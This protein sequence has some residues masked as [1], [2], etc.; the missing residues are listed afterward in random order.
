MTIRTHS[1]NMQLIV[2]T[3]ECD[4]G[5][6]GAAKTIDWEVCQKHK[7]TLTADCTL[8]FSDPDG[9][10]NFVFRVIQDAVGGWNLTWP[11]NVKWPGGSAPNLGVAGQ[12]AANAESIVSV[13]FN[14]TD[15]YAVATLD[16]S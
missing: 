2:F 7:I 15:Y 11:A 10:S 16:F 3:E 4:N 12:G 5:N 13:Y 6:S 8:T 14:G 1:H 9:V